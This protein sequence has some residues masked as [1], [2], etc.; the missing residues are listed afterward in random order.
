MNCGAKV[1]ELLLRVELEYERACDGI[2][3]TDPSGEEDWF[4]VCPM[5]LVAAGEV[6]K[7]GLGGSEPRYCDS[8]GMTG[9]DMGDDRALRV[10]GLLRW[11]EPLSAEVVMACGCEMELVS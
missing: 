8:G 6:V 4:R 9:G 11:E 5:V 7:T 2:S 1:L 10:K 3:G